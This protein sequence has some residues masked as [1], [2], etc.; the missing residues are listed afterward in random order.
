MSKLFSLNENQRQN[1]GFVAF[2]GFVVAMF[3][4]QKSEESRQAAENKSADFIVTATTPAND[5]VFSVRADA[6]TDFAE[7]A[8]GAGHVTEKGT[9]KTYHVPEGAT[10]DIKPVPELAVK[11]KP[12]GG[13]LP[14]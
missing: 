4:L 13:M 11:Q 12:S 1:I 2:L 6:A 8:G 10:V 14:F 9:G 3:G 5:T 7:V